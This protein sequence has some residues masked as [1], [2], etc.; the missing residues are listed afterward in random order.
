MELS[1]GGGV[2]SSRSKGLQGFIAEKFSYFGIGNFPST[3][4]RGLKISLSKAKVRFSGEGSDLSDSVKSLVSTAEKTAGLPR[5]QGYLLPRNDMMKKVAFTLAEVLITLGIIGVVA[6]M[7]LPTLI[8]N[9]QKQVYVNQLKKAYSSLSQGFTL[10]MAKEGVT[11]L[12][13]TEAFSG[14]KVEQ[15]TSS[16]GNFYTD[17]CKSIREA[18]QSTFTG[19]TF[20]TETI[21]YKY[22]NGNS[23]SNNNVPII[24]FPD[25]S[26]I[27]YFIFNQ[28]LIGSTGTIGS[29]GSLLID[30]NGYKNPNTYGRDIFEFQISNTGV[31]YPSGSKAEIEL[32]T[33]QFY[34]WDPETNQVDARYWRTATSPYC[35]CE[36]DGQSMGLGCTARVLE[37]DAMNY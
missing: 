28:H 35:N 2:K 14:I 23:T 27:L 3:V 6:A 17:S 12:K 20:T 10:M 7:T 1:V 21:N 25:G 34:P 9:Y 32:T 15:C 33:P 5:S 16:R 24:H 36:D 37:E 8:A 29:M 31:L 4:G 18:L 22:L 26:Y 13:D 30:V 19:I 11:E